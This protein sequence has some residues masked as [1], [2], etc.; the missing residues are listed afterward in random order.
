MICLLAPADGLLLV[1]SFVLDL[2]LKT[3]ELTL[4]RLLLNVKIVVTNLKRVFIDVE[5]E[6][7]FNT[8]Y[9]KSFIHLDKESN[10]KIIKWPTKFKLEAETT[11]APCLD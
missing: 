8:N 2:Q 3:L 11:L 1:N 4:P 6:G 7:E 9:S 5:Y 10:R